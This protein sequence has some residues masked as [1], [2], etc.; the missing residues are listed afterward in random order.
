M[1]VAIIYFSIYWRR[2]FTDPSHL[3]N[4]VIVIGGNLR[5]FCFG[6]L[7]KTHP[8]FHLGDSLRSPSDEDHKFFVVREMHFFLCEKGHQ[9]HVR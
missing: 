8:L 7:V 5:I 9:F 3:Q 1:H 2:D 6:L 4:M